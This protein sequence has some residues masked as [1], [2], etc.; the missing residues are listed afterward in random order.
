M[1]GQRVTARRRL[2][3]RG[4][5]SD[6]ISPIETMQ[7]GDRVMLCCRVTTQGQEANLKDQEANLRSVA[8][9]CG[10]KVVEVFTHVGTGYDTDWLW[11]A[12]EAARKHGAKLLAESAN[13]LIRH[14]CYDS[15]SWPDAQARE[16]DLW[17]LRQAT[18]GITLVTHLHPDATPGEE[19]AYHTKRGQREK[20]RK[21]GR[22]TKQKPGDKKRRRDELLP[23]VLRLHE[24]GATLG[25]IAARTGVPRSTVQDWI[26]KHA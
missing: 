21:G 10:A 8:V 25:D 13:R 17:E 26:A 23:R 12:A 5:A 22:P 7:P 1:E 24:R 15:K 2:E 19:R 6:Y 3:H 20:G 16:S 18:E 14:P 9:G 11:R 4:R